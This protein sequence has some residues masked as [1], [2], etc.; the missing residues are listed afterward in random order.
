MAALYVLPAGAQQVVDRIVAVVGDNYILSSDLDKEFETAKEQLAGD[1]PENLR[2]DILDQL[3][4]K[5][6]VLFKAQ[7][8]SVA[9]ADDR[10]DAELD[11]RLGIIL[12]QFNGD[13]NAFEAYLGKSI[14]QFKNDT[15]AKLREQ[16]LIQEMEGKIL[17]DVKITPTDVKKYYYSIPE[18][19]L[20]LIGAEVEVAQIMIKPEV[21]SISREYAWEKINRLRNQ[22]LAGGD[23]ASL[24]IQWSED[25]GSSGKGGETGF[26]GRGQ[27]VPEFE[28][29]A[30]RMKAEDSVSKVIETEYGFHIMKLIERRGERVNV[31]HILVRPALLSTDIAAARDFAE[32]V[33]DL[34]KRDSMTFE[35]AAKEFS[36]DEMTRSNGGFI[37][38][39]QTGSTRISK[40]MLE[41]DV[42]RIIEPLNPGEY[43]GPYL[44]RLPDGT[45]CYRIYYLKSESSPHVANLKDDYLKLQMAAHQKKKD[46]AL[47]AWLMKNKKNYYIRIN[48]PY[49]QEEMLA[50][51]KQN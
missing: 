3:I 1:I 34:V 14:L 26:F 7:L 22:I 15:R 39:P 30:F 29:M 19:S 50:R 13:E 36:D 10:V 6:I 43:A 37:I 23:F 25:P 28:A 18:D 35:E 5:K 33:L 4:A 24:A 16:M 31:R 12:L 20:P 17:K 38:D 42:F 11:R 46:D 51:W 2:V 32:S 40:D 44:K 49:D 21:N 45:E 48:A 9:I 27:M 8:D 47:N 41:K